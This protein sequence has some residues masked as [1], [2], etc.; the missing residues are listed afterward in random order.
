VNDPLTRTIADL[1]RPPPVT[2][3]VTRTIILYVLSILAGALVAGL[4]VLAT[5]LVGTDPINWR[6]VLAAMIGPIVA[7]LAASRL[8]RPETAV[9]AQQI[10]A[11][12]AQGTPRHEMVV[13]TQEEAVSGVA[14][15]ADPDVVKAVADELERRMKAQPAG[16]ERGA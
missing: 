14:N 1:R 16:P 12:K 6:P 15:P 2:D 7:G 10:D 13:V 4:G 3:A 8:P 11:L 5:Q 9:L